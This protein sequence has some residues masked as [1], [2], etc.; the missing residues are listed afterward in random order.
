M[1]EKVILNERERCSYIA[2]RDDT[3]RSLSSAP[4]KSQGRILLRAISTLRQICSHG[5]SIINATPDIQPTREHNICDKCGDPINTQN[6]SQQSFHGTCG[7][8]VCYECTLD[9]SG[10]E[11]TA[12][13]GT[14]SAC[15]ICQEHVIS[16]FEDARPSSG[17]QLNSTLMDWQPATA[18]SSTS[19]SS[20]IEKVVI[21]LQQLEQASPVNRIEPI[22]R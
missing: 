5:G 18:L 15:W 16:V 11:D 14:P 4:G 6:D 22:K 20:K 7:H 8:N 10:A 13:N 12:L 19:H 2:T 3:K 9:Q 21:N 17:N 1:V